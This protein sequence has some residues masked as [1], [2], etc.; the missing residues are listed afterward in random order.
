MSAVHPKP[1]NKVTIY[2]V[3]RPILD[4]GSSSFLAKRILILYGIN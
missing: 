4:F 3:D 1:T 2:E